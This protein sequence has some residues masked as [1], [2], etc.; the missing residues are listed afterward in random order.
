MILLVSWDVSSLLTDTSGHTE[1]LLFVPSLQQLVYTTG[2]D[3]YA[4]FFYSAF[5]LICLLQ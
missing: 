1:E 5:L 4:F 2:F 3:T